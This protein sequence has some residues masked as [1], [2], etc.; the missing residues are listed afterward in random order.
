MKIAIYLDT[1][2]SPL[3]SQVLRSFGKGIQ[4]SK[5]DKVIY[6][7]GRKLVQADIAVILGFFGTSQASVTDTT[8]DIRKKIYYEQLRRKK[9]V[10]FIDRDFFCDIGKKVKNQT[11]P[12]HFFRVSYGSIYF[13]EGVHFNHILTPNRWEHIKALKEIP[14]TQRQKSTDNILICLNNSEFGKGW[15]T[16]RTK[17]LPWV[18]SVIDEVRD[19]SDK[20]II[21]RFH[22]KIKEHLQGK[23]PLSVFDKFDNIYFTG[24]ITN[25]DPRVLPKRSMNEDMLSAYCSIYYNSSASIVPALYGR[26]II[27]NQKSCPAYA[28]A[29]HQIKNIENLKTFDTS[30]WLQTL[31]NCLWSTQEMESGLLWEKFRPNL[32]KRGELSRRA[33]ENHPKEYSKYIKYYY[34][35]L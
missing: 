23:I 11:D 22:P 33:F 14:D 3:K 27:T 15:A 4:K 1:S 16:K 20:D 17:M 24:G 12:H 5:E 21:V 18:E 7:K 13:N 10:I 29:N 2:S 32:T 19:Y 26:P 34:S 30:Q 8:H 9:N 6:V 28:V 35:K 31:S 25:K